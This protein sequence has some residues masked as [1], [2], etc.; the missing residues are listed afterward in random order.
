MTACEDVG[1]AYPMIIPIVKA[2]VDAAMQVGLPE[3]CMPL[4]DAVVLVSLAPKP[5]PAPNGF[6]AARRDGKPGK[7]GPI[8]PQRQKKP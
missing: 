6:L 4:S 2:A 7:A 5:T 1:L 3:A 8:P